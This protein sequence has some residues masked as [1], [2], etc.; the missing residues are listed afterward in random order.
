MTCFQ[1]LYIYYLWFY[2]IL[3][4]AIKVSISA[5]GKTSNT[6]PSFDPPNPGH[7]FLQASCQDNL[8]HLTISCVCRSRDDIISGRRRR[9]YWVLE[10]NSVRIRDHYLLYCL[11]PKLATNV[12]NIT[13]I[14]RSHEF[15]SR[16]WTVDHAIHAANT[17]IWNKIFGQKT[18]SVPSAPL[19]IR[20]TYRSGLNFTDSRSTLYQ[21]APLSRVQTICGPTLTG[22]VAA[23]KATIR[24][25]DWIISN[26][27]RVSL[28]AAYLPI[29]SFRRSLYQL[30]A[31]N[32]LVV[33]RLLDCLVSTLYC[34]PTLRTA[35]YTQWISLEVKIFLM[36]DIQRQLISIS[37]DWVSTHDEPGSQTM[38]LHDRLGSQTCVSIVTISDFA[39]LIK[40]T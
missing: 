40:C 32:F 6:N 33:R 39:P 17:H 31:F 10:G 5:S 22:T 11:H 19:L 34:I 27:Q 13:D 16:D 35:T 15:S 4:N 23:H 7:L 18:V 21:S 12:A 30:P 9:S 20:C 24:H 8:P 26:L 36:Q 37:S 2:F 3:T 1:S 14:V 28:R 25:I 38:S 29:T